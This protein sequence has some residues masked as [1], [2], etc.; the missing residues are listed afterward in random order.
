MGEGPVV[1]QSSYKKRK[2]SNRFFLTV[3]VLSKSKIKSSINFIEK[4][5]VFQI[6]YIYLNSLKLLNSKTKNGA[7]IPRASRAY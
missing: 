7:N 6:L 5:N 2:I 1:C 3:F 4:L